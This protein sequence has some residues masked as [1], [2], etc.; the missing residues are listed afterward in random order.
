MMEAM[1]VPSTTEICAQ[2]QS[3]HHLMNTNSPTFSFY[4]LDAIPVAQSTVS[5]H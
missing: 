4:R 1:V 3:D 5:K 2:F